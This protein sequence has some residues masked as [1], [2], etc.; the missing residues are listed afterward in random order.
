MTDIHIE[1]GRV[2]IDGEF[3]ETSLSIAGG[4]IREPGRRGHGHGALTLDA[5]DLL[6]LPGIVDIHG[7][8]FER[9]MMPRPKVD[10][11]IDVALVDSDR[12]AI[13]NGTV[14]S[15]PADGTEGTWRFAPLR[16]K[17]L[18][19]TFC[20]GPLRAKAVAS[21][22]GEV[23]LTTY[24]RA[25]LASATTGYLD[26]YR[27]VTAAALRNDL[28]EARRE[29]KTLDPGDRATAQAWLDKSDARDAALAASHQFAADAIT[30]LAKPAP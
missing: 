12:Q 19:L 16:V 26:R 13:A 10:F 29:L 5:R 14:A 4:E 15:R 3:Q 17:P 7:D 11:P 2:L 28:G 21:P 18:E 1:A 23:T 24:R 22:A 20:A 9:Q 30:A 8:A 6:V 25:G 27:V